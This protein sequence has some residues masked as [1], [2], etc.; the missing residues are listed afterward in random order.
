[1]TVQLKNR[2]N[3][4]FGIVHVEFVD[5]TGTSYDINKNT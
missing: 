1:M 2:L 3:G 5:E 4:D